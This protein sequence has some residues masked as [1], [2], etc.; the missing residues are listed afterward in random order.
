MKRH[1]SDRNRHRHQSRAA[2][3]EPAPAPGTDEV[4]PHVVRDLQARSDYGTRHYGTPLMTDNGRDALTDAYQEALDLV[5]YLK[6]TLLE[7]AAA[8]AAETEKTLVIE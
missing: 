3:R 6:Q 7:R 8:R 5:M 1:K 2:V 4:L